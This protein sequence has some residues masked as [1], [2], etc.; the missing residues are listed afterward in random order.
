[1][2][3][4]V[5]MV[6][7]LAGL[8]VVEVGLRIAGLDEP[9]LWEPDPRLGWR[10]IPDARRRWTE[11]GDAWVTINALGHRDRHRELRKPPG[12]IRVAL[13]GDS[14][15]EAVQVNLQ[16]TFSYRVEE[17]LRS[18]GRPVEVLNFAVN[19]FSP[20]QELLLFKEEGPKY[21]IDLVL[22]ALFLD[23]DV[24][25]S[26]PSLSVTQ[27]G[28][29]FPIPA[30][31]ALGIDYRASEASFGDYR[32]FP[33]YFLRRY[34][35]TYRLVSA[36]RW[37]RAATRMAAGTGDGIP[38]RYLLYQE[39]V[40]EVWQMA[41]TNMEGVLKAFNKRHIGSACRS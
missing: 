32:R 8:A 7:T 14:M 21:G 19:G 4:I 25:G 3:G 41:W 28:P 34:L 13:F 15:T 40:P 30:D 10:H 39:D 11:E 23:N 9:L 22:V 36:W 33:L 27:A 6:A 12:T 37:R 1:M 18:M 31:G 2:A 29:P 17:R 16:D 24:S 38:K 5:M 26:H 35:G 20:V